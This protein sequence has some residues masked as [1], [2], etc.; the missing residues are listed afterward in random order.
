MV[1][2]A[3][4]FKRVFQIG[5][6]SVLLLLAF[7]VLAASIAALIFGMLVL[8]SAL[9]A[10]LA[11]AIG[12]I[13]TWVIITA[14]I[15]CALFAI[16]AIIAITAYIVPKI[17]KSIAAR[18]KEAKIDSLIKNHAS[19]QNK[20]NKQVNIQ[21][22]AQNA[23]AKGEDKDGNNQNIAKAEQSLDT[24]IKKHCKNY[25]KL[26]KYFLDKSN[27]YKTKEIKQIIDKLWK[28]LDLNYADLTNQ[29]E[30]TT[31]STSINKLTK[32]LKYIGNLT[33]IFEVRETAQGR[34]TNLLLIG[35]TENKMEQRTKIE[36]L[37]KFCILLLKKIQANPSLV[38]DEVQIQGQAGKQQLLNV[39]LMQRDQFAIVITELRQ[40][41]DNTLDYKHKKLAPHN[42]KIFANDIYTFI[43]AKRLEL[44]SSNLLKHYQSGNFKQ[45]IIEAEK[46]I[47][48]LFKKLIK[49]KIK[50]LISPQTLE[51]LRE[52]ETKLK[53][54]TANTLD[55]TALFK[56]ANRENSCSIELQLKQQ[57]LNMFGNTKYNDLVI[58]G[59]INNEITDLVKETFEKPA[60][61]E[62][63]EKQ[64]PAED[65]P[66]TK[67]P[68]T[69]NDIYEKLKDAHVE[70]FNGGSD[71]YENNDSL[72]RCA[73]YVNDNV[74]PKITSEEFKSKN[75]TKE[76]KREIKKAH[77]TVYWLWHKQQYL[78]NQKA[79]P[80]TKLQINI[81]DGAKNKVENGFSED[82]RALIESVKNN[83]ELKPF[84]PKGATFN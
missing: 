37:I 33:T 15:I 62:E 57:L 24:L 58:Y 51:Q 45:F 75:P 19:L 68:K 18:I 8:K 76:I 50:K 27:T 21:N 52:A 36:T 11:V 84:I 78:Q 6:P 30:I 2:T 12:P 17:I 14:G 32:L 38:N 77:D 44:E 46:V 40:I 4:K 59:F 34:R 71:I 16:I 61:V 13:W 7:A 42:L 10:A 82:E 67:A 22:N 69:V 49:H 60:P 54:A 41:L 5:F 43:R 48:G 35:N 53:G 39:F 31:I 28:S 20:I 1:N 64:A 66:K 25:D 65:N 63:K 47:P 74:L 81:Q 9:L 23:I 73:K 26:T 29:L 3:T 83:E 55:I 80:T 79:Q 56:E 70:K 72:S